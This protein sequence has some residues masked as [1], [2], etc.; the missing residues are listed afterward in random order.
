MERIKKV[1]SL[2]HVFAWLFAY[3]LICWIL[4][5]EGHHNWLALSSM[6]I[7]A[8]MLVFYGHFILLTRYQNERK[9]SKYFL[10]LAGLI[11]ISPIF[12][13]L[14][15]LDTLT[16]WAIFA[17]QYF[18]TLFSAVIFLLFLS[19]VARITENSFLKTLRREIQDKQ[20]A[21]LELDHLKAQIN[22]HFLFN[23]L[24]NIHALSYINSE[25]TPEAIM[26]L[27]SLMRYMFYDSN[28]TTVSLQ[29]E[30]DHLLDYIS[31][32][33]LRYQNNPIADVA[34][35]GDMDACKIAPLLFIHL[36]ENAYKH[37]HLKLEAGDIK[38]ALNITSETLSL[39]IQ[40]P[41]GVKV[42][43]KVDEPGGFGLKNVNKRLQL[44][45]PD[46]H[47]LQAEEANGIFTVTLEIKR[48][49][50]PSHER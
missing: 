31:L 8:S 4:G 13:L 15:R 50:L 2:I 6:M 48:P 42:S 44:I 36:I 22:P 3:G 29:L 35:S 27:S 11:L 32:Q 23:T 18:T 43:K 16:S 19:W 12:F 5:S 37:S 10:A 30:V 49:D 34:I 24:N 46:R 1:F 26:K 7:L 38:V 33:Q 47:H 28:A 14:N 45:Y 39:S 9:Y 25:S 20:L 41:V 40:N 21:Q 17:D